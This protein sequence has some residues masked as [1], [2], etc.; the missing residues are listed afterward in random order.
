MVTHTNNGGMQS[1]RTASDAV[2]EVAMK[3]G[4]EIVVEVGFE[5]QRK[6]SKSSACAE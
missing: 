2:V 4:A 6:S 3:H 1:E 5:I